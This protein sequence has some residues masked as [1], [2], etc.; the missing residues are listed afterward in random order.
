MTVTA[1]TSLDVDDTLAINPTAMSYYLALRHLPFLGMEWIPGQAPSLP[2]PADATIGVSSSRE[3]LDALTS[4]MPTSTGTGILLSGGIDSAIL[5]ALAEPGTPTFTITFDAPGAANESIAAAR[6]AAKWGH[7]HHTVLVTWNDYLKHTTTLMAHKQAPL[8]PVEVPLH[9]AALHAR[10][11]GVTTLLVGN[12]ADSTFGGMDK[13]LC[14]QWTFQGFL[15]RY[16]FVDPASVLSDPSPTDAPFAP[17]RSGNGID[18][19]RFLREIH[20][21]GIVQSFEN[22]I[23]SAGVDISAPYEAMTHVG[24][25]DL[26]RIRGGEPKYLLQRL[27]A[28]LYGTSDVPT[29]VPFARPMDT[30]MSDWQGPDPQ[31][32]FRSD[33]SRKLRSMTGEQRFLV[34][35]LDAFVRQ[36]DGARRH[37]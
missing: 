28:D 2:A 13:L 25:L 31:P 37:D 20:G 17:Y 29:K 34:W 36:L 26:N 27:F 3:I 10:S 33:L 12:G 7:P 16:R 30:W 21:Q 9:I 14:P 35:C 23:R 4:L 1:N 24:E 18:V 11:L 32:E 6:Y 19:Q 15:D 5:A 22:A 8:H